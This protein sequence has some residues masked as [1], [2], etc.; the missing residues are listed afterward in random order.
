MLFIE[1]S[2]DFPVDVASEQLVN[3]VK[4]PMYNY[5]KEDLHSFDLN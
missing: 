2:V 5:P 1:G 4:D 3:I